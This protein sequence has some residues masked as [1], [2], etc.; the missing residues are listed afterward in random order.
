MGDGEYG[1]TGEDRSTSRSFVVPI[2]SELL[3]DDTGNC[4][5]LLGLDLFHLQQV[6]AAGNSERNATCNHNHIAF[7]SG[8]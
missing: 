7:L 5:S 1:V 2:A 3:K 6:R 8:S 4:F